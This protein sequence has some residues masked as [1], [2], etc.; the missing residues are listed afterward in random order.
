MEVIRASGVVCL[1]R[2]SMAAYWRIV[3]VVYESKQL[4]RPLNA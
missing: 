2:A 4:K 1:G 3:D